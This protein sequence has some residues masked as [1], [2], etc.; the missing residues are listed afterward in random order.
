MKYLHTD[1][2]HRKGGEIVEVT[3]SIGANVRLMYSSNFSAYKSGRQHRF[4]GGLAK[5]SPIRLQIPRS[6]HWH[7]AIDMQ[8]LRGG[9]L[10][11][12][13][14]VLPGRLPEIPETPLSDV[15]GLV[16]EPAPPTPDSTVEIHDVFISHASEDKDEIVNGVRPLCAER[17]IIDTLENIN[18]LF[19]DRVRELLH[20]CLCMSP[21][22]DALRIR[23]RQ[24]PALVNCMTLD[25][26]GAWPEQALLEVS[27]MKLADLEEVTDDVKQGLATMCMKIHR[28]VE[29]TA[30]GK[31]ALM[32]LAKGDM[33]KVVNIL[34]ATSMAFPVVDAAPCAPES[35]EP[36]VLDCDDNLT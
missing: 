25:F 11:S 35:D 14:Q 34:Q 32:K 10:R 31:T 7:V 2:G 33:R 28:S 9:N 19:I 36:S 21:V 17:K 8:G 22:G 20:I 30:E 3:L 29:A 5:R 12:S 1:L 6:G 26:F 16:R 13:V 4:Y 23:C 24:F 15:P 27:T 18:A